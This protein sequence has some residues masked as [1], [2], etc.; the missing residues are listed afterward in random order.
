MLSFNIS[1]G[2]A[3]VSWLM[4]GKHFSCLEVQ[5]FKNKR[6]SSGVR[7]HRSEGLYD[8]ISLQF[9]VGIFSNAAGFDFDLVLGST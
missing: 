1:L 8:D 9:F 2:W 6:S 4:A 7:V 3:L 5:Y